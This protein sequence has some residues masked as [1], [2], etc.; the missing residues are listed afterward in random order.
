MKKFYA[1][2][3]ALF[4]LI[5][6]GTQVQAQT[7][8]ILLRPTHVDISA[9]TSRG[10]VLVNLSDYPTDDVRYRLYNGTNQYNCWDAPSGTFITSNS[11]ASGPQALG[12]PSTSSS[13][14][15]PYERGTNSSTAA[16]YRDRL[17]PAYSS[18]YKTQALPAA[19]EITTPITLSG[20]LLAGAGATLSV[21]YVTL[22]YAGE[23]IVSASHSDLTTGAFGI[24]SPDG[25]TITKVQV[26]TLA[27]DI[28]GEKTGSWSSTTDIGSIQLAAPVNVDLSD[29]KV[30]GNTLTDFAP[31]KT[32]YIVNLAP[33][34]TTIPV[35]TATAADAQATVAI[36]PATDLTGDKAARTTTIVVTASDGTTKKTYTVQFDPLLEYTNIAS[37]RGATELDRLHK[38]TGEA[39]LTAQMSFRN[40]KYVQDATAAI[41]IDDFP[42][43]I[44]TSYNT[45]D[46]IT[47]LK[48]TMGVV[49]GMLQFYPSEDPGA[50]TSQD[51]TVT[52]QVLTITDFKTNFENY[53]SELIKFEDISFDA[54]DVGN[55]FANGTS[56]T[57]SKGGESTVLRTDFFNVLTSTTIPATANVTGIAIEYNGTAQ[58]APR[59]VEDI[60]QATAIDILEAEG[61]RL[62]PVPA[63]GLL[64]IE[65]IDAFTGIEV[66][67]IAGKVVRA[68]SN[69][70]E[71]IRT[72]EMSQ[73]P[74]GIYFIRLTSPAGTV[75]KK[76]IKN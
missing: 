28:V 25:T 52:P 20:T 47:G 42:G 74:A 17:G 59:I 61:I 48:G 11:Y 73:L 55:T 12:T 9:E 63:G 62:Y 56:Y 34:I 60:G 16:S 6:A 43:I 69:N 35:V 39:V 64:T 51:N 49:N 36:T 24:V 76:F 68:I 37:L 57:I 38:L 29:L 72:V 13:F 15:I 41:L 8:T 4:I 50:K 23:T 65:G 19:T 44:T 30:D 67:N 66:R 3:A 32:L 1:L 26:R 75:T 18:N 40:K 7:V 31:A 33:G 46:G 53:E 45:G 27:N 5:V 14:W 22:A 71:F 10:A 21:K 54:G 2:I 70:G 58:I